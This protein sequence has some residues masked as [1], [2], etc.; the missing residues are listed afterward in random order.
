MGRRGLLWTAPAPQEDSVS[1]PWYERI[2]LVSG[3]E[4]TLLP[5]VP[6]VPGDV[7]KSFRLGG[8]GGGGRNAGPSA[9]LRSA[10]SEDHEYIKPPSDYR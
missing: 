8:G 2:K 1:H 4:K 7:A 5:R 3:L 6:S 9:P 10:S